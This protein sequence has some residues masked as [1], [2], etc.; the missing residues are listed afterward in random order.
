MFIKKIILNNFRIFRGKHEFDFSNKKVIVVEGPNGHGKSTI[1]DAINWVISGK[2]S[3]YI[4]SS[5]HQQFNYI[6]NNDAYL[7]SVNEASVAIYFN[8]EK[9]ITIKRV[10]KRN[11][12]TKLFI[13]GK[14]TGLRDGQ[15]QIVQLL[16]NEKIVNN[17]NSLDS[18]DLLSFIESTLILSQENLEGFVRGDKPTERYSKLE[19]ILGLTRYGQDFKDYLQE[20]TKE[21]MKEYDD[22]LSEQESLKHKLELLNVEYQTKMQQS[23]RNGN[24]PKSKILDDLNTFFSSIQRNSYKS[25]NR[26]KNFRDITSNEYE[27]L[28]KYIESIEN[29]LSRLNF[30]Q[31]EIEQKEIYVD[32]L[33]HNEKIINYKK[34]TDSLKRKKFNRE[35]GIER[36]DSIRGKLK[37]ISLANNY[38]DAKKVEKE[39][40]KLETSRII[41]NL[42]TVS[43]NIGVNYASLTY[44]KV[45]DFIEKYVLKND[46]L[47]ELLEKSSILEYENQLSLLKVKAE[48]LTKTCT[49]KNKLVNDLQNKI[50]IIDTQILDL[51]NQKKS[52]L[53]SQ[54]NTIIH[55]V[56]THLLNS[57]EQKCLVCGSTFNSNEELNDSILMQLEISKQLVNE[58]EISLN[59]YKVKKSKFTVEK[60]ISKEDL[61][62]SQQELEILRKEIK[63]LQ[64]KI[65]FMRLN[66]SIDKEDVEQI[67]IEI[68]KLQDYKNNNDN[69]YK[70]FIHIKKELDL[71]NDLKLKEERISIEEEEIIT[72]HN[73][74]RYFI[75]EQESLHLKLKKIENYISIA[76]I[77]IQE[78]DKKILELN[79]NAQDEK[80]K[81]QQL[82]QIKSELEKSINFEVVLN[83]NKVLDVI[84]ENIS[85]LKDERFESRNLLKTIEKYMDDIKLRKTEAKMENYEKEKLVVQKQIDQYLKI[86]EQL[87]S[88]FNYHTQVQSSLVNEYLNG[89]SLTINNYFRQISPHSYFNYIS[90]L[91][92]KNELFILLKDSQIE[93]IDIASDIEDSVNASLTL[94][95]AQST[96]LAM[97]IFLALNKSQNWSKL[98][99]I[100]IDDPFQNLDD[101]NAYSFIDVLSNLVSVENRQ[102]LISTHDSDFARLTVKKMNLNSEDYAY[103]KIQSYTRE[104]IE[105]QS[106]QYRSCGR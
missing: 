101:I 14:H 19:K 33:E 39:T 23:E 7:S 51:N 36:A 70:G 90:L 11:G 76:K 8:S 37:S 47:K 103:I 96:I 15:K 100:G 105:I 78:Y 62:V 97:S 40:I 64:N 85:F 57:N 28:K 9:E 17:D 55:E 26:P 73:S 10:V 68:K 79:N 24:K 66:N 61:K 89:I 54:I 16:V 25:F 48:M 80:R 3:R 104:A 4:G 88:L 92:K 72:K 53:Q 42:E 21:Y 69:K 106:D 2:I 81:L 56:Q 77:R 34:K 1:F 67:Q 65:I 45:S 71:W 31:F 74:Y 99:L 38:L 86:N 41:E 13:N 84:I 95:A 46:V 35:K 102:I 18:I 82:L 83:S 63:E 59:E 98:N 12:S 87:K 58:F 52:N 29:E 6:M 60:K 49:L 43:N 5:E 22:I 32:E 93:S 75:G 44:E 30:L 20:L 27:D 94:S 91:T 50:N